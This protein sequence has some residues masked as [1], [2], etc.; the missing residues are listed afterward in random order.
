M[1]FEQTVKNPGNSLRT[2]KGCTSELDYVEQISVAM[3]PEILA[4]IVRQLE[5]ID[6]WLT[7]KTEPALNAPP[8]ARRKTGLTSTNCD[9]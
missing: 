9:G 8:S 6:Q 1:A 5:V 7:L 4:G 3:I 2:D